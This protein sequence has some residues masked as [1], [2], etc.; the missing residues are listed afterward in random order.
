MRKSLK[1]KFTVGLLFVSIVPVLILF[2]LHIKNF[3]QF[4]DEQTRFAAKSET[5]KAAYQIDNALQEIDELVVSLIHSRYDNKYCIQSIAD[6]ETENIGPT[7]M[8][9]LTNYREYIYICNNLICN[10]KYV[11]GVYLFTEKGYTYSYTKS[12]EFYLETDYEQSDWYLSMKERNLYRLVTFW[13]SP[14]KRVAGKY[15]LEIR[16]VADEKGTRIAYIAVVCN[17]KVIEGLDR[18]AVFDD[19]V[20]VMGDDGEILYRIIGDMEFSAG[21]KEIIQNSDQ[22]V[23]DV[24]NGGIV[25]HTLGVNDWKLVSRYGVEELNEL[26]EKNIWNLIWLLIVCVFFIIVSVLV[27]EKHFIDPIVKLSVLMLQVPETEFKLPTK[28]QKRKDEIGILYNKFYKMITRIQELIQEQYV[29]Q[30]LLLKE[31]LNGLMSQINSHFLFNTLE[32]INSLAELDGNRQ[33]AQ[34]SKLLGNMLHYSIDFERTEETLD[35]EMDNIRKYVKIQEIRF[36]NEIKVIEE[37]PEEL[38]THRVLKFILQPIVENCIEHGLVD[39][40][41]AWWIK[42]SAEESGEKLCIKVENPGKFITEKERN[43]IRRKISQEKIDSYTAEEEM[44]ESGH[45]IGLMNIQRRIQIAYSKEYGLELYSREDGGLKVLI[46]LP[47]KI[48]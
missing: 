33:I 48:R 15:I 44:T 36:G 42:I 46:L 20:L 12:K 24:R 34:M 9:R 41:R 30:I 32:N 5:E 43:D 2:Y 27:I 23:I 16:P 31:K 40:E 18:D 47:L 21:E 4:Y 35:T 38:K 14:N 3:Y 45:S 8:Q 6:M 37:I 19:G 7:A 25:Y 1:T 39:E 28:I 22:G 10:N 13:E 11:E 26:Y 17:N 29:S